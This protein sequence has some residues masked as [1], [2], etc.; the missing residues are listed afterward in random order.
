MSK[1]GE[2]FGQVRYEKSRRRIISLADSELNGITQPFEMPIYEAFVATQLP[3]LPMV[4]RFD[5]QILTAVKD[6][7][8]ITFRKSWYKFVQTFEVVD[9]EQIE[10]SCR[11]FSIR[12][13][14]FLEAISLVRMFPVFPTNQWIWIL[15][16]AFRIRET[17]PALNLVMKFNP[18]GWDLELA[19][20][21][22]GEI[23]PSHLI[24]VHCNFKT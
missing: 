9:V 8:K 17:S 13:T 19:Q 6:I 5:R 1:Q 3:T 20:A 15:G 22:L 23:H 12:N 10:R 18:G 16:E 14:W 24:L 7:R 2:L 11:K 21:F 4:A